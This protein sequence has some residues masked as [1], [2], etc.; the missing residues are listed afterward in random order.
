MNITYKGTDYDFDQDKVT[1]DEW[2]EL[3]RKYGMTPKAFQ[4]AID[5]ADPDASTFVWWMMLRQAGDASQPL[6]DNLKPDIIALNAALAAAATAGAEAAEPDPT[7]AGSLP[8]GSTPQPSG[9]SPKTSATSATT[10]SPASP[11]STGSGPGT[12]EG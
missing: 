5:E 2:R 7:L 1:V 12:S 6:G 4:D 3:K 9:S 10:T 8:A 11:A